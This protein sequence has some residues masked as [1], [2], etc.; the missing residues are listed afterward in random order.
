MYMCRGY[1]NLWRK[2]YINEDLSWDEKKFPWGQSDK[3]DSCTHTK[4][5]LIW[6]DF[7]RSSDNIKKKLLLRYIHHFKSD[8]INNMDHMRI[9]GTEPSSVILSQ[10]SSFKSWKEISRTCQNKLKTNKIH[11]YLKGESLDLPVAGQRCT[12]KHGG[13]LV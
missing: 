2:G 9:S 13:L 7:K 4:M 11:A 12:W 3:N 8:L 6:T 10:K 5:H 1:V